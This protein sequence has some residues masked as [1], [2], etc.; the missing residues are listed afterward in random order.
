M[1][2][3]RTQVHL[4]FLGSLEFSTYNAA[5]AICVW[6]EFLF[7]VG[8][9]LYDFIGEVMALRCGKRQSLRD[10]H[11]GIEHAVLTFLPGSS[12]NVTATIHAALN[13]WSE[14][15]LFQERHES[16][17]T[18]TVPERAVVSVGRPASGW[19]ASPNL[20]RVRQR[21][22]DYGFFSQQHFLGKGCDAR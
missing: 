17:C 3:A 16:S 7:V 11:I 10:I 22:C 9:T 18:D 8:A 1:I 12:T 5:L 20:D 2:A 6:T 14:N 19:V 15:Q 4:F 13:A 21:A